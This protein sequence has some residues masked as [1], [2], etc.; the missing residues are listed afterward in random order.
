MRAD[1]RPTPI[2]LPAD[3]IGTSRREHENEKRRALILAALVGVAVVAMVALSGVS[4]APNENQSRSSTPS[5]TPIQDLTQ[6][7][8]EAKWGRIWSLSNGVA[9]LRPTWLPPQAD[10]YTTGFNIDSTTGGPIRYRFWYYVN[11]RTPPALVVRSVEF[12]VGPDS[13]PFGLVVLD[14]RPEQVIVRGHTAELMGR[15]SI[16]AWEV[17][18]SEFGYRY[19]IQSFGFSR[20]EFLRIVESLRRLT[21]ETGRVAP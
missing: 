6:L 21:D 18:W 15:A 10:G 14:A 8:E 19:G 9:V 2:V 13:E 1:D 4:R 3:E 20:E 17:T 7:S 12:R 11:E 16:P 5:A